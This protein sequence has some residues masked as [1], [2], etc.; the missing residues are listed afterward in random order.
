MKI[1]IEKQSFQH[2]KPFVITGYTFTTS[3]TVWITLESNGHV[4]RGETLGIYYKDETNDSMIAQLEAVS[5]RITDDLTF[6]QVQQML[7]YGGA[8]NALDCALWDLRAKQA[9]KSVWQMLGI[10]PK[11]LA[12]VATVSIHTH[13]KMAQEALDYQMYKNL[14]V[15][16]SGDDPIG[17]LEA[18]RAVRPDANLIVDVN[19]GWNFEELKEYTPAAK[20]LGIQMIEQPLARGKDE[21]LEG[22]K[23]SVPLG[24]DES[25]LDSSEY[26]QSAARYDVI[27]IKLDK[28]G[29]LTDGLKI[30]E[31]AKADGK[32]LMVGNMSGSSLS[33]APSYVIG[34]F[35]SFVDIDGPLFLKQDID[36]GLEYVEGGIVSLPTTALW[37]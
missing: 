13:E 25:C 20:K 35:C 5:A 15:K 6:E 3:D 32:G 34:Q 18:I 27:N 36:N 22:Y 26:A 17:R 29:G 23:S 4:G 11:K 30:V 7:P 31:L 19:Q 37:G 12:T 16:L 28:C 14:K 21:E 9:G 1:K 2:K 33:M 8:R 10:T 24:S